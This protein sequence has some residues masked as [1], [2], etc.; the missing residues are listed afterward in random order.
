TTDAFF[1]SRVSAK[2][3]QRQMGS[4]ESGEWAFKFSVAAVFLV[5]ALN[6]VLISQFNFTDDNITTNR[7]E[8]IEE[9]AY[10]YQVFDLNYYETYEAE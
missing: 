1:Y 10:E 8:V 3:E 5:L 4:D 7:E 6:M 2:L 9:L